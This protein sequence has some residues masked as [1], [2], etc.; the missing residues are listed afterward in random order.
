MDK[1]QVQAAIAA[2]YGTDPAESARANTFLMEFAEQPAAW[3]VSVELLSESGAPESASPL[4]YFSANTLY[5]K[6]RK[7]WHQLEAEH[8]DQLGTVILQLLRRTPAASPSPAHGS[9]MPQPPQPPPL[10][11]APLVIS[12]LCLAL[13]AVAVRAPNGVEAY[14]REAFALSSQSAAAGSGAEA[15][16]GGGSSSGNNSAAVALSLQMIKILPQEV[17]GADLSRARRVELQDQVREHSST[18]LQALES[19][20][21]G[22]VAE[23]P[24]PG[25]DQKAAGAEVAGFGLGGGGVGVGVGGGTTEE[26]VLAALDCLR[27]WAKLGVS[28]GRLATDRPLLLDRVVRLLGGEGG[29]GAGGG[30]GGAAALP[31]A[32]AACEVMTELLAVKEYPRPPAQGVPEAVLGAMGKMPALFAAAIQMKDEESAST[33]CNAVV[34]FAQEEMPLVAGAEGKGLPLVE[35][36]LSLTACDLP[37]IPILTLDFWLELQDVPFSERHPSLGRPVYTRLLDVLLSKCELPAGFVS[38]DDYCGDDVDEDALTELRE[39]AQ[40]VKD[41]LVVIYYILR[42]DYLS[43]VMER[44]KARPESW[45]A[46][47]VTLLAVTLVSKEIREWMDTHA[48]SKDAERAEDAG[49]TH[50]LVSALINELLVNAALSSV[51][52]VLAAGCKLVG[53]FATLVGGGR[54]GR[55]RFGSIGSA[56]TAAVVTAAAASSGAGGGAG[57]GARAGSVAAA[58]GAGGGVSTGGLAGS[59][60]P[61]LLPRALSYL[62]AGLQQ[63]VAR[64]RA[65]IS[66]RTVA[67]SC[68]RAIVT[69]P[70]ALEALL[71]TLD[72]ATR[73]GAG[74][75]ERLTL[76]EASVRVLP[77]VDPAQGSALLMGL[78]SPL[79][80]VLAQ[81]LQSTSPD[82]AAI[83]EALQLLAQAV[84]FLDGRDT[85]PAPPP[86]SPAAGPRSPTGPG[87]A[88]GVDGSGGGVGTGQPPHMSTELVRTLWPMLEAVPGR[89]GGSPEVIR[90]LFLLVGKLLTSLRM[91]LARQVHIPTLLKMIIDSYDEHQYPCCLDIMTTAVEV[92][93]A[94]D[95]AVEHFR[96]LLGRA[97]T[98]TFTTVQAAARPGEVPQLVRAYFE[99]LFRFLLFCPAGLLSSSELDTALRLAVACVGAS[100]LERESARAVLVFLGQLAGRCG[101]QLDRYKGEVEAALAP[102]GEALTRLMFAAL[103]GASPSLLWPNLIDALYALLRAFS[104]P[105]HQGVSRQWVFGALRDDQV[106]AALGEEER[107][108]VMDAVF[109]LLNDSRSRFKALMLDLAKICHNEMTKDGL[110]AYFL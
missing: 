63:S 29:P 86:G 93:G 92:Y 110:L 62:S 70:A 50:A 27:E 31:T 20:L 71:Q 83:S 108:H 25:P 7:H 55:P 43:H 24:G 4:H 65:A 81:G 52:L 88:A 99:L 72:V 28:V 77:A 36:L 67:A 22:C 104:E 60:D 1:M 106:C 97:S 13:A 94:A 107:Q 41:V 57:A 80:H 33:L 102:H 5:T 37:R 11:F 100:D 76:V 3:S 82:E 12:R 9:S 109:R 78:L 103:A 16:G 26:V 90:Q 53:S 69:N 73:A 75:E 34:S 96:V 98:R 23:P 87:G 45:Q 6:V 18:V 17:D 38:W 46:L 59:S 85:P 68:E 89:M 105:Q 30:G 58:A 19:V 56:A 64:D 21:A 84:R 14:V 48:R 39:G 49:R 66:V 42:A 8:R 61:S 51:P 74:V 79:M 10:A 47:E 15:S 2:L 44:L 101:G 91:V 35:L 54:Y 40:G 95:E 32:C